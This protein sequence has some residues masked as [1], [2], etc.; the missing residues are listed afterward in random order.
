MVIK[1]NTVPKNDRTDYWLRNQAWLI[2]CLITNYIS[3]PYKN[4][5]IIFHIHCQ[6]CNVD[7]RTFEERKVIFLLLLGGGGGGRTIRWRLCIKLYIV[8]IYDIMC[9]N[10]LLHTQIHICL[11]CL[12][13]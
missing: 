9:V 5:T 10:V 11:H 7:A 13:R 8:R 4:A 1:F 3:Q 6:L 2:T 12:V